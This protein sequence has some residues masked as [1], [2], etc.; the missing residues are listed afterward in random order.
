MRKYAYLKE[1]IQGDEKSPV[2]KI[3]L[4]ETK[5]GF[6]LFEYDSLDAVQCSS[7]CCYDSLE[8]LFEDWNDLIDEQGWIDIEDPLPDCQHDA[9]IPIRVKGRD[10][11]KPDWGVF[12]TLKDGRWVE[13]KPV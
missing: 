8:D 13:Y 2:F 12:E 11:G 10:T 5:E 1:P 7:D 6:Y 4:Y 9:F 3:M